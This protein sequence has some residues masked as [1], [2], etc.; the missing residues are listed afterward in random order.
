MIFPNLERKKRLETSNFPCNTDTNTALTMTY[1]L[2]G[3]DEL[4][5]G[6]CVC[7]NKLGDQ[8]ISARALE[9]QTDRKHH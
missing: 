4:K 6:A 7:M 8:M 5:C 3:S 2:Y 9:N 1:L